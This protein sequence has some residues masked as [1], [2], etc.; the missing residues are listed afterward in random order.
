[1]SS[2][3]PSCQSSADS[4][5]LRHYAIGA[6]VW[7]K[8][9]RDHNAAVGLLVVFHDRHPGAPHGE[10]APIQC[11]DELGLVLPF[12][13][14]ANVRAARLECFKIRARRNL[15]EQLLAW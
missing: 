13:T 2:T 5:F 8:R 15:A 9:F 14:I 1:M 6:H 7:T 4:E 12:R 3:T 10:G 11:M